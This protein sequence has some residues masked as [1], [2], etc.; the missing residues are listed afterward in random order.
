MYCYVFVFGMKSNICQVNNMCSWNILE[1]A[2]EY[3]Y[4]LQYMLS[5]IIA[6]FLYIFLPDNFTYISKLLVCYFEM[7]LRVPQYNWII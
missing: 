1:E 7:P 6:F 4:L 2:T 3:N 5:K